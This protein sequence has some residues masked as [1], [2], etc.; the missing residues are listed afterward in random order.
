MLQLLLSL[1]SEDKK[2]A[3]LRIYERY[4]A[5]FLRIAARRLRRAQIPS[6]ALLAEDVVQ[7][8]FVKI[9]K[10]LDLTPYADV[11]HATFYRFSY[12]VLLSCIADAIKQE[13]NRM[14]H[15]VPLDTVPEPAEDELIHLA[16]DYKSAVNAIIKMDEKYSTVL[17]YR[18]VEGLPCTEIAARLDIP[19][20]TVCVRLM[21]GSEILKKLSGEGR[22]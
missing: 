14:R 6:Y 22:V 7:T 9:I 5:R 11:E 10:H 17:Y 15:E 16:L 19:V 4:S 12:T 1:V 20:N 13:K 8:A 3:V 21:R 18:F 2:E